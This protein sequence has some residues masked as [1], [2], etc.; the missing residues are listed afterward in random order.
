MSFVPIRCFTCGKVVA[1]K[2]PEYVERMSSGEDS[3]KI[4]DGLKLGRMC[5]RRMLATHVDIERYQLLYPVYEDGIQRL[6]KQLEKE[7]VSLEIGV[8]ED[9]E[10]EGEDVDDG[11]VVNDDEFIN[12]E[13]DLEDEIYDE[14]EEYD[15]LVY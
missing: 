1:D 7:V 6:G 2:Y 11:D 9:D 10:N 14:E 8:D 15:E 5:C 4:L 13:R 12:E 3:G